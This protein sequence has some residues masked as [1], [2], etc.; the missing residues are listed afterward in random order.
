MTA[1][2]V[3]V[4]AVRAFSFVQRELGFGPSDLASRS[5]RPGLVRARALFAWTLRHQHVSYPR[6]GKALERDRSAVI[7]LVRVAKDLRRVDLGFLAQCDRYA[8]ETAPSGALM[9]G[10]IVAFIEAELGVD[11][12]GL[13]AK[14][15]LSEQLEARAMFVW[16]MRRFRRPQLSYARIGTMIDHYGSSA[17]N[18]DQLASRLMRDNADFAL[19]CD[20]LIDHLIQLKEAANGRASY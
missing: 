16:A 5:R 7:N 19:S 10:H 17:L 6:I 2:E 1:A 9:F 12:D 4:P 8:V 15:R 13:S 20:R 14:R 3:D 11:R 18:L